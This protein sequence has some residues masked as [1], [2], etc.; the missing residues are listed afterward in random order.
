M[1]ADQA[2][3]TFLKHFPPGTTR[4]P[5]PESLSQYA[6]LLPTPVLDLWQVG[7]FGKYG[8]GLLELI[9]PA[10]YQDLLD[11]WLG[12]AEGLTRTPFLLTAFGGLYFWRQ[13]GVPREDGTFEEADVAFLSPQEAQTTLLSWDASVFLCEDLTPDTFELDPY[14]LWAGLQA[15]GAGLA[16]GEVFGFAPPLLLGGLPT[17]VTA[18]PMHAREHL[19][20]L[21]QLA[22]AHTPWSEPDE[23]EAF[24]QLETPAAFDEREQA[25]RAEL[26]QAT[27]PAEQARLYG[28]IARLLQHYPCHEVPGDTLEIYQAVGQRMCEA[29]AAAHALDPQAE[30]LFGQA[31]AILSSMGFEHADRAAALYHAALASGEQP[32][33]AHRGL[34]RRA[35][36]E[37]DYTVIAEHAQALRAL[38]PDD[39]EALLDLARAR[40]GQGRFREALVL[41]EE[42][43]LLADPVTQSRARGYQAE[44]Y[45]ALG[46]ASRAQALFRSLLNA[47]PDPGARAELLRE[48][49]TAFKHSGQ[50]AI[51]L[52][53]QQELLAAADPDAEYSMLTHYL[54]EVAELHSE[55]G[56][57]G[58]ALQAA[59]Q[60]LARPDATDGYHYRLKGDIL[61]RAGRR[62]EAAD[63]YREALRRDP[64]T[65]G[66]QEALDALQVR[67][68]LL[69]RLF[70]GRW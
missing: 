28:Q 23:A 12:P 45:I 42:Y 30:W 21:R 65:P 7:G 69:G 32:Q 68:G 52:E 16:A 36:L 33:R 34:I 64:S 60:M 49:V 18:E 8:G 37:D 63:A 5:R 62:Q 22:Q 4:P 17:E 43:L 24:W 53:F 38:D 15:R 70:G 13:L 57:H 58:P 41:L 39:T 9:D 35:W 46:E 11:D 51:A 61:G 29:Y 66:V 10:E 27:D 50:P 67:T 47:E 19:D 14:G 2:V 48:A 55:L 40:Q 25:L 3:Q 31:D 1:H 6:G 20:L 44:C 59:E 56:Q 54:Y 26:A